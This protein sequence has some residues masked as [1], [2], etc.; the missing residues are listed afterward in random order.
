[1]LDRALDVVE[2]SDDVVNRVIEVR[3]DGTVTVEDWSSLR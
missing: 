2:A 3:I 1:L